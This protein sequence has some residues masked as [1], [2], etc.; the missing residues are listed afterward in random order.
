MEV[1]GGYVIN[2][3]HVP[4]FK[5]HYVVTE[6]QWEEWKYE[7]LNA[8]AKAKG[9]IV[10]FHRTCIPRSESQTEMIRGK[11]CVI[12]STQRGTD[13]RW[14]ASKYN[15]F[16]EGREDRQAQ[17]WIMSMVGSRDPGQYKFVT[18]ADPGY[19]TNEYGGVE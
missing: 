18:I 7:S 15:K 16:E 3:Q 17:R 6:E 1:V 9:D 4:I 11:E 2:V 13:G 14:D 19:E 5:A 10:R 12:I 8:A